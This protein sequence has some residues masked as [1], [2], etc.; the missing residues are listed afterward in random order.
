MTSAPANVVK[1]ADEAA[2]AALVADAAGAGKPL[3]LI[4]RGTRR[5][6]G[7]PIE[8]AT[9]VDLSA[10]DGII[11]YAPEE[12]VLTA[13]PATPLDVIEAALAEMRQML[14]FE[15]PRWSALLGDRAGEGG[16]I[17]G[18]LACNLA[19]S[20][21]IKAGAARDHFLGFR[22]VNGRGEVFKAGGKVVKNVTGYDLC[23]LIAGSYGTLAALSEVT[24]K[25][26]PAPEKS[27]T[28]LV[29][30]LEPARAIE[31]LGAAVG[32]PHEVSGA[33]YLPKPCAARST[34]EYVTNAGASV[35]ALRVEGV[36]P[37]VEARCGALRE[38]L[39]RF[40]P[41]E[42]LH[43]LRSK[44]LWREIGEVAPL[45]G[46]LQ[47][48]VVWRVSV[49]PAAGARTSLALAER[50]PGAA[51]LIDWAGGLIWAA[52]PERADAHEPAVRAIAAE[53][54]GYATLIRAPFAIRASVAVFQPMN[55]AEAALSRRLKESFDPAGVFNRG[56]MV[57]GL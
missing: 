2:L 37:S 30:G 17:G 53:A 48:R 19:G 12:L 56:R 5:A 44:T 20:R 35:A 34:V 28:V 42:E 45:L 10:F 15:P 8:S 25:V 9:L 26:L 18:V 27:R 4:G 23:K 51:S 1:P 3:E 29:F 46:P 43:S 16:S 57:E 6:L 13:G 39:G 21:R 32:S 40:G 7:R 33:A 24:V 50:I 49:P 22:G 36:G 31:A 11:D 47:Q 54:G 38:L 41:V 55:E 14:A 52:M